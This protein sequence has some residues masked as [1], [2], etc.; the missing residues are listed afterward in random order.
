M[1]RWTSATRSVSVVLLLSAGAILPM[2]Q[3][4][5]ADGQSIRVTCKTPQKFRQLTPSSCLNS[6]SDPT[7]TYTATVRNGAGHGVAGVRVRF[8]DNDPDAY[9]RMRTSTCTT[10]RHGRCSSEVV[11]K[12]AYNGE[13]VRVAATIVGSGLRDGGKLTFTSSF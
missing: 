13:V 9:F 2:A 12:S 5:S 6:T 4:S 10:N 11:D 8:S 1:R 3:S 7:Q